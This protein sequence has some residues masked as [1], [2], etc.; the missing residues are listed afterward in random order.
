MTYMEKTTVDVKTLIPILIK[1]GFIIKGGRLETVLRREKVPVELIVE[2]NCT[3]IIGHKCKVSMRN[4][5]RYRRGR[6]VDREVAI[7]I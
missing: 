5:E 7:T 2:E 6:H 4:D 1:E 3:Q